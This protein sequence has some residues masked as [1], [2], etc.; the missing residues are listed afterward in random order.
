MTIAQLIRNAMKLEGK[1]LILE[2]YWQ[3][4]HRKPADF[5]S[6]NNSL[7]FPGL[8]NQIVSSEEANALYSRISF[9]QNDRST[10]LKILGFLL[11]LDNHHYVRALYKELLHRE[12]TT[13]EVSYEVNL[14]NSGPSTKISLLSK[15]ILSSHEFH[16]LIYTQ[17]LTPIHTLAPVKKMK[18]NWRSLVNIPIYGYTSASRN[19]M[20]SLDRKGVEICYRYAYGPGTSWPLIENS[21]N[22]DPRIQVFKSRSYDH[23]HVEVTFCGGELFY[24]NTGRYKIGYTMLESDG[25]PTEWGKLCNQM[26][27]VWVPSQFNYET[28][29]SSGVRIPIYIMPLGTNP[30][31]FNPDI[32]GKRYSEKFTFLSVFQWSER[33]NPQI[34]IKAFL[35]AFQNQHDV[36]LVLKT[37]GYITDIDIHQEIRKMGFHN[38]ESKIIIDDRRLPEYL[39]GCVY[40]SADCF[41]FPTG[42]EGWGMPILE[43]MACGLPT[44]ATNWSGHTEFFNQE[45]GYPVEIQGFV[46]N[47]FGGTKLAKPNIEQLMYLMRY[48]YENRESAQQR[49]VRVANNIIQKFT[50]DHAAQK[51]YARLKKIEQK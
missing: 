2:L 17:Q 39:M 27:E 51:I 18:L 6:E 22:M 23:S 28:F 49:S 50:W 8:I 3:L 33:K 40:R 45:T 37:N 7:D 44:I 47:Y 29:R 46:G 12:P 38:V 13:D 1:E 19:L 32:P 36:V 15:I 34:L 21:H 25:I 9:N 48:V 30:T 16:S 4:L 41:V 10:I 43:A 14:I 20:L 5:E 11:T 35:E 42:G 24:K 26:N 31:F